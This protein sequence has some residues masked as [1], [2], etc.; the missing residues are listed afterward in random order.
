[1]KTDDALQEMQREI[2]QLRRQLDPALENINHPIDA[3]RKLQ[4]ALGHLLNASNNLAWAAHELHEYA[5]RLA[6]EEYAR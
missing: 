2:D 1:M 6:T 5:S 4:E 3:R